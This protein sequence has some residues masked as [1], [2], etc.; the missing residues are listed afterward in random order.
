MK[1]DRLGGF[2]DWWN[3]PNF[4]LHCWGVL[5]G[6][7]QRCENRLN[8]QLTDFLAFASVHRER[9]REE[10]KRESDRLARCTCLFS[11]N[12]WL[13]RVRE[14]NVKVTIVK[15]RDYFAQHRNTLTTSVILKFSS[16]QRI[17]SWWFFALKK[18]ANDFFAAVE[19]VWVF[20]NQPAVSLI[21]RRN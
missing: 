16:R 2:A 4:S 21:V 1:E 12:D 8:H 13:D 5:T 7:E 9:E 19:R 11:A 6:K 20:V 17:L 18:W 14:A 15:S 10:R 3:S